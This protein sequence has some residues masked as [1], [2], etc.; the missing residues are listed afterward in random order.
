MFD[1]RNFDL[2]QMTECGK[3]LRTIGKTSKTMEEVASKITRF[4][5]DE[6]VN[7]DTGRNDFIL[8]HFFKTHCYSN[9]ETDLK[10]FIT[11]NRKTLPS[12]NI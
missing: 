5:Y 7:V 11:K 10:D 4:F 6:F 8:A 3:V 1:L 9:L 12:K 2:R